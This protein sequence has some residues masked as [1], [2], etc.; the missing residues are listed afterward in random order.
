[1]VWSVPCD[2]WFARHVNEEF[3]SLLVGCRGRRGP[4]ARCESTARSPAAH[5]GGH[6]CKDVRCPRHLPLHTRGVPNPKNITLPLSLPLSLACVVP[7]VL[8]GLPL[9]QASNLG[10]KKPASDKCKASSLVPALA[11]LC[12][13]AASPVVAQAC[14]A[15][16]NALHTE[17][18]VVVPA[19]PIRKPA[20][21]SAGAGAG[22]GAG[23][24]SPAAGK[25]KGSGSASPAAT[26]TPSSASTPVAS[27]AAPQTGGKKHKKKQEKRKAEGAPETPAPSPA[28]T[29]KPNKKLKK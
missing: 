5:P 7:W 15:C 23:A 1:M 24:G 29:D 6:S 25:S 18:G 12:A 8:S 20:G 4:Q 11:K 16:L 17:F 2:S 14:T 28:A 26:P 22:T 13:A 27:P 3:S 21:A 19:P 10:G 9:W